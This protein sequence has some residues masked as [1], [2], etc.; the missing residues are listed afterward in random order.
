MNEDLS[1]VDLVVVVAGIVVFE[2]VNISFPF[3]MIVKLL[4]TKTK[5]YSHVIVS[6]LDFINLS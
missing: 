6:V 3:V 2:I 1:V 4:L 5:F